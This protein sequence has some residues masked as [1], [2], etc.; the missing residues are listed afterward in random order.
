MTNGIV[1]LI[2]IVVGSFFL[3]SSIPVVISLGQ[4]MF[5]NRISTISSIIIIWF[6]MVFLFMTLRKYFGARNDIEKG[7]DVVQIF[8]SM[9]K[10]NVLDHIT[11][12]TIYFLVEFLLYGSNSYYDSYYVGFFSLKDKKIFLQSQ[13]DD[14]SLMDIWG[15]LKNG[16][17]FFDVFG[18]EMLD[19]SFFK[20]ITIGN[21]NFYDI[22]LKKIKDYSFENN[23]LNAVK[24][25]NYINI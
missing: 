17:L 1:S 4:N 18:N 3:Y 10:L 9:Y 11:D 22:F 13:E 25:L 21:T 2:M 19:F 15:E 23:L 16:N 5:P 12:D 7:E 24:E 8:N 20:N 14:F 6:I